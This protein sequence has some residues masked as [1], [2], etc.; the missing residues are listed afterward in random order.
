MIKQ[1]KEKMHQTSWKNE[2]QSQKND[3]D[4]SVLGPNLETIIEKTVQNLER[5]DI[6]LQRIYR[7]HL[8]ID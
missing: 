8:P 1:V 6:N 2:I 4:F 5:K 7:G 3:Q